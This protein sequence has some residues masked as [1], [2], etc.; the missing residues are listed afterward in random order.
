MLSN[1]ERV[2]TKTETRLVKE[3]LRGQL[4]QRL[5]RLPAQISVAEL[6]QMFTSN[7]LIEIYKYLWA[8][9]ILSRQKKADR[10]QKMAEGTYI[11]K[12]RRRRTNAVEIIA[13]A[14]DVIPAEMVGSGV[15]R[16]KVLRGAIRLAKVLEPQVRPIVRRRVVPLVRRQLAMYA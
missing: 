7:E 13:P 2:L 15:G 5:V 3:Y 12:P 16:R 8:R 1:P 10:K 9:M 4:R 6:A 14:A 11:P